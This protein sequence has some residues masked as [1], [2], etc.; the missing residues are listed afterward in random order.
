MSDVGLQKMREWLE[1]EEWTEV[2]HIE[3]ADDKAK[4]LHQK[5]IGKYYRASHNIVFALFFV[6]SRLPALR[7]L[8]CWTFSNSPFHADSKKAPTLIPRGYF[9]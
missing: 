4:M 1:H 7:L 6:I 2:S 3:S 9:H 8:K 5:L